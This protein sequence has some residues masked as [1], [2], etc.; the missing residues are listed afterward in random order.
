MVRYTS[1]D[2]A[3]GVALGPEDGVHLAADARHF[4]QAEAVH[5]LGRDVGRG[6]FPQP[7]RVKG[8]AVGQLP[9]AVI[10]RGF[11]QQRLQV[12]GQALVAGSNRAVDRGDHLLAERLALGPVGFVHVRDAL[13]VTGVKNVVP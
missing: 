10:R 8:L 1:A 3:L 13:D 11:A 9:H 5:L 2:R 4:G 6:V 7:L 12:V